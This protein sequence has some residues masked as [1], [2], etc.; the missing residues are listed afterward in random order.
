MIHKTLH[1][2]NNI[3]ENSSTINEVYQYTMTYRY[4]YTTTFIRCRYSSDFDSCKSRRCKYSSV[5]K[6][7]DTGYS[8]TWKRNYNVNYHICECCC[9]AF[10]HTHYRYIYIYIY[11]YIYN[12]THNGYTCSYTYPC[13]LYIGIKTYPYNIS[14]QTHIIH[15]CY[16]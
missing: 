13:T 6:N 15:T 2:H 10:I 14:I 8:C 1:P 12:Y 9:Y 16:A 3:S 7:T 11:I 4:H 5:C